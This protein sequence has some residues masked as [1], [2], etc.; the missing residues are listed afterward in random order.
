MTATWID[1]PNLLALRYITKNAKDGISKK[2]AVMKSQTFPK[3]KSDAIA[4]ITIQGGEYYAEPI[5][6]ICQDSI[7]F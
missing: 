3:V 2:K 1:K 7:Y 4:R 6:T 5:P